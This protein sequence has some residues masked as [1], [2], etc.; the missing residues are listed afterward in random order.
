MSDEVEVLVIGAGQGGLAMGH[1]LDRLG[2]R[3]LI[4]DRAPRLGTSWRERWDSLHLFTA[5]VVSGLPGLPL[6]DADPFPSKDQVADHQER[7]AAWRGLAIRLGTGVSRVARTRDGFVAD[8]VAGPISARHVVVATGVFHD[9]RVP[10]WAGD[11]G[12]QVVQLHSTA[13]RR[14]GDVPGEHIAVVGTGA[15]GCEIALDLADSR[16][17]TLAAGSRRPPAPPW[18]YSVTAWRVAG[19]RDRYLRDRDLPLPWPLRAGRY[20]PRALGRAEREGR[21]AIVPRAV[22]A[23]GGALVCADGRRVPVDTVIWATGY[24]PDFGWIE[25][26]ADLPRD[27]RGLPPRPRVEREGLHLLTGRF[28]FPLVR[29]AGEVARV[30]A[31]SG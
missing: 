10:P 12:P 14:P 19:L 15:S 2:R 5:S 22:G 4:V 27:G 11:L 17:V 8:T 1:H 21:I 23:S 31:R 16:R 3:Y 26:L 20:E 28:L 25:G 30:I 18:F 9:P 29:Q 6:R 13:Y 7:Y 24:R